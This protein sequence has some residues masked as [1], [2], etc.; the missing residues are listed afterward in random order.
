VVNVDNYN[1]WEILHCGREPGG[2]R[3]VELGVC[4]AAETPYFDGINNGRNGGRFC[5]VVAGTFCEGEVQ[6]TFAQKA[7]NC[8]QCLFYAQVVREQGRKLILNP[9]QLE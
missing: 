4:P 8:M 5:W 6:G 2:E 9:S 7:M 3:V 1:C